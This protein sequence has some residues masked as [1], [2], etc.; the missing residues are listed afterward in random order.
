VSTLMRPTG[1]LAER[2]IIPIL[3]EVAEAIF[4]VHNQGIIHWDIKCANV[5]LTEAGGVQ[6]CD[7]GVA[8]LLETRFDKRSTVTGTLQW[9]PP[10][11]LTRLSKAQVST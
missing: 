11:F 4:W 2:W 3:R 5:L 8:G 6:L 9:W 10:S 1:G 7:F